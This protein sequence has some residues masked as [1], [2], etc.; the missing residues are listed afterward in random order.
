MTKR[1]RIASV[2]AHEIPDRVPVFDWV[3]HIGLIEKA[4]GQPLT[5]ENAAE[6]IPFASTRL[7]DLA[8]LW[9][10]APAERRVDSRGFTIEGSDWFN[11]WIVA[12]PWS[13]FDGLARWVGAQVEQL[14]AYRLPSADEIAVATDAQRRLISA[15]GDTPVAGHITEPLEAAY[16]TIGLQNYAYLQADHPDLIQHWLDAL[17]AA[18]LAQISADANPRFSRSLYPVV[19]LTADVAFKGKPIFSPVYLRRS[20]YF[21]RIAEVCDLYHQRGVKVLFHSDGDLTSILPELVAAGIDALNPIDLA[22]GMDL[23]AVKAKYGDRLVLVGG[24]DGAFALPFGSVEVA[25]EATRAALRAAMPGG[26]YMLGSSGAE[27]LNGL[28]AENLEAMLEVVWTEGA[29]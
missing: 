20:G 22:A 19:C 27:W 7:L 1:E 8:P 10:P 18:N 3:S 5:L 14:R 13:D 6:V 11:Q 25:R 12:H 26:G 17:H 16:P 24:V 4:A 2:F 21:R 23:A 15:Y 9:L 28:P 29:Y